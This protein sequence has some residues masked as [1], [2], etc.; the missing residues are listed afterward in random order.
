M[1]R[2]VVSGPSLLGALEKGVYALSTYPNLPQVSTSMCILPA[3]VPFSYP[4][5][6]VHFLQ[7]LPR[8][9]TTFRGGVH[10]GRA[11]AALGHAPTSGWLCT[12]H[13]ARRGAIEV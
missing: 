9:L 6:S 5:I 1:C 12:L 2:A 13:H 11:L 7:L 8:P 4:S 10:S 3:W